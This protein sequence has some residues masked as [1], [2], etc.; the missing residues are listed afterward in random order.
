MLK[1]IHKFITLINILIS[2]IIYSLSFLIPKNK[3][4]WVFTGWHKN[5]KREVFA[6]NSKYL[7]LYCQQNR[8]NKKIVWIGQDKEISN[9]LKTNSLTSYPINS[10]LGIYYSLRAEYT[11]IDAFMNLKNWRYSGN[12]KIIQLWHGKGMKKTGFDSPYSL[13]RYNNFLFPNLFIKI[14]KTIAS[15]K[16]TAKLMSSTFNV[17]E[18][19]VLITGLPR[20]DAIFKEITK[21]EIDTNQELRESIQKISNKKIL[22]AP[23][24]RPDGNNPLKQL[25]LKK[26][27]DSLVDKKYHLF[28]QLHPKF[29]AQEYAIKEKFDNIFFSKPGYDIY[30]LLKNFDALITDYSS[31]YIDFLL[32]N[33]PIIFFTY[34]IEKYRKEMGLHDSFNTATPGAH[35]KNFEELLRS[36]S[37]LEKDEF[38]NRRES[39]CNELFTFRDG[40]SS[41]RIL[42]DLGI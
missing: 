6:D 12:S 4:I 11:F 2:W 10:L 24:F 28:I 42:E 17:S 37:E 40:N 39:I 41:K 7:F 32:L 36:I 20:N 14:F 5:N 38:R 13:Q 22:Y 8:K 16:T 33:H 31:I 30:P 3:N 25:D 9:I 29:A 18:E 34:D 35:P 21:A 23:T 1:I 19:N 27:N 15:S 26:L